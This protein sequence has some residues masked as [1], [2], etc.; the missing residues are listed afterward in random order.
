[1][2]T[3]VAEIH[4]LTASTLSNIK[5]L[6]AICRTQRVALAKLQDENEQHK[7]TIEILHDRIRKLEAKTPKSGNYFSSFFR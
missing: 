3:V 1:M 6:R 2:N 7:S 5:S 4:S